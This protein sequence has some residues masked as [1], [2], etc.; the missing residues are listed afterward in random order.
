MPN[1]ARS[2]AICSSVFTWKRQNESERGIRKQCTDTQNL[3]LTMATTHYHTGIQCFMKGAKH[4][5]HP[6]NFNIAGRMT[7]DIHSYTHTHTKM[8]DGWQKKCEVKPA[9]KCSSF[10]LCGCSSFAS[11]Q[12]FNM[13]VWIWVTNTYRSIKTFTCRFNTI[14]QNACW[15][16]ASYLTKQTQANVKLG[17]VTTASI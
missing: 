13:T 4:Q 11:L 9:A 10:T 17:T 12:H 14:N 1:Q 8:A 15:G 7:G 16:K 2:A 6:L 3:L 5:L